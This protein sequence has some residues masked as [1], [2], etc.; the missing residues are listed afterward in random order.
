[1]LAKLRSKSHKDLQER[2]GI[3]DKTFRRYFVAGERHIPVNELK[4]VADEL[5]LSLSELIA[6]A[7]ASMRRLDPADLIKGTPEE[8][9]EIRAA[10]ARHAEPEE[11]EGRDARS[12]VG[13]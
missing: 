2:T 5:G 10:A 3:K 9:E 13:K 1:M 7:E 12:R 11:P 8:I 6:R 4:R